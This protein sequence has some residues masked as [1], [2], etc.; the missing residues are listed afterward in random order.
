MDEE[1]K[2]QIKLILEQFWDDRCIAIEETE[3]VEDLIDELDSLSAVDVLLPIE[4]LLGMEIEPETVIR[5]GGYDSKEQLVE[6]LLGKLQKH[7]ETRS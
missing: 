2:D 1:I 5:R 3:D 7:V 4:E 6:H